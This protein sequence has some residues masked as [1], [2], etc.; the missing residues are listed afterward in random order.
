AVA[1]GYFGEFVWTYQGTST[2]PQTFRS[3]MRNLAEDTGFGDQ[4][5][6]EVPASVTNRLGFTSL[7]LRARFTAKNVLHLIQA[8][9][10]QGRG[11]IS[12]FAD[13]LQEAYF[14][15]TV[16]PAAV[17]EMAKPGANSAA[18]TGAACVGAVKTR[19]LSAVDRMV[20][21]LGEMSRA[22]RSG[23]EK[24]ATT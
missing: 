22:L 15:S 17:C 20:S 18:P 12:G 19:T 3:A 13:S 23:N 21:S 7:T 6:L 10:V 8:A 9:S 24:A 2:M 4:V 11:R 1:R 16:N 5:E 14:S